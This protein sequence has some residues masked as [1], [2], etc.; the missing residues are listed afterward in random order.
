[1]LIAIVAKQRR[2]RECGSRY[3]ERKRADVLAWFTDSLQNCKGEYNMEE[4]DRLIEYLNTLAS[5]RKLRKAMDT[6]GYIRRIVGSSIAF[7]VLVSQVAKIFGWK[8]DAATRN[9]LMVVFGMLLLV[10]FSYIVREMIGLRFYQHNLKYED[11]SFNQLSYEELLEREKKYRKGILLCDALSEGFRAMFALILGGAFIVGGIYLE[12][13]QLREG[14]GFNGY[15][16]IFPLMGLFCILFFIHPFILTLSELKNVDS[17][18]WKEA[19]EGQEVS[20]KKRR[21]SFNMVKAIAVG[22]VFAAVGFM[23]IVG[24]LQEFKVNGMGQT[25]VL[26]IFGVVFVGVGILTS[27]I[28]IKGTKDPDAGN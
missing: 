20:G 1:M 14:N 22:L 12:I 21:I 2:A 25:I 28:W 13:N 16:I 11:W 7:L 3:N 6:A 9:V 17:T 26:C 8:M 24:S 10:S 19:M 27:W 18:G 4:R 5:S 23:L 15:L